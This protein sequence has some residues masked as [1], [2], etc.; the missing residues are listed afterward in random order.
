VK[1]TFRYLLF[2][3][4]TAAISG[5]LSDYNSKPVCRVENGR[6]IF[7]L[8]K[9]WSEQEKKE[10]IGQYELDSSLI[11]RAFT[12][13]GEVMI[14]SILWQY[15]SINS[16]STELSKPLDKRSGD[17]LQKNEILIINDSWIRKP[18]INFTPPV[19]Y[20]INNFRKKGLFKYENGVANFFLAK[21][22]D[23][24]NVYLSGTFNDWSTMQMPM[25]LCDS[26]W[27]LQIKL[28]QGKYNYKFIVDG[29]WFLDPNN[30]L[31]E[32]DDQGRINSIVYCCNHRFVLKDKK[33]ARKVIVTGNFTGWSNN[34][35]QMERNDS[36]WS[37]DI[38]LKE[39]TYA[40]KYI[41]D[42]QWLEDKDNPDNRQDANG[43]INSFFSIGEKYLFRLTGYENASKVILTGS[44]NRWREDE[45]LMEKDATGWQLPV[46][47]APGNY[48]YKFIVDGK[49]ITDPANPNKTGSGDYTNSLMSFKE[50]HTFVLNDFSEAVNVSVAGSFNG[51]HSDSYRMKRKAGKW[52]LPLYLSPGKY[53][54]KFVVDGNWILDP[55]NDLYEANEYGTNNSVLWVER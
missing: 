17:F 48:E 45:L 50:N 15:R 52:I 43:N 14:D 37:L 27:I 19:D 40:Y 6:I 18:F 51:W 31:K 28:Q 8:D 20:G 35:C 26:G 38:Y 13:K 42:G 2:V 36:G 32:K 44:F 3:F 24:V 16:I 29:K 41:A 49:W 10:F 47:M 25:S 11:T 12:G 30:D 4:L 55:G 46:A 21:N 23:A 22:R 53:T 9:R 33:E 39:G 5:C 1:S 7:R 54:Y 34:N